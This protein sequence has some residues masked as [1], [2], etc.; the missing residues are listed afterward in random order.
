MET[1]EISTAHKQ[2]IRSSWE[3]IV[4]DLTQSSTCEFGTRLQETTQSG[5]DQNESNPSLE[6]RGKIEVTAAFIKLFEQYPLSQEYFV[7]FKGTPIEKI[8]SCEKHSKALK[9]HSSKLFHLVERGI[10]RMEP[11][12]KK[13]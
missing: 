4:L 7:Q 9:E 12:I 6:G 13:V 5:P 8:K 3:A 1:V 11:S 2:L 10:L